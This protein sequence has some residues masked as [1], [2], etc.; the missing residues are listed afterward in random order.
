MTTPRE[1]FFEP[2]EY[3]RRVAAVQAAMAEDGLDLLVTPSPGNICYVNGYVSMNVLDIMFLCVPVEGEAVFYLWQFERGRAQS[4][5]TGSETVCWDTGVEPIAFVAEDLSRRGLGKGRIGMDIGSI[6]TSFEV[7]AGHAGCPRRPALPG[8]RGDG[9]PRQ[10]AAGARLHPRGGRNHRRRRARRP[11][12]GGGRRERLGDRG[13]C[14]G[15]ARRGGIGVLLARAHHLRRV[16]RG[17]TPQ[18]EGAAPA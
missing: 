1:V 9:A 3:A 11:G 17:S 5:V 8:D 13:R 6:H 12:R 2:E 16:A 15:R 7:V 4:T 14:P 10:V 18:P